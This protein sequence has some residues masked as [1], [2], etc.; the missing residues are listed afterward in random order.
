M[1]EKKINVRKWELGNCRN[2]IFEVECALK[3]KAM[4]WKIEIL[5]FSVTYYYVMFSSKHQQT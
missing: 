5:C 4:R 3:I 2:K 1:E